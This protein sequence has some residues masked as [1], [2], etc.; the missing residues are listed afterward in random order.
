[1][2]YLDNPATSRKKPL[3]VTASL[4]YNSIVNSSNAGRG[5]HRYS[6]RGA[7]L[8]A[9][10]AEDTARLF[11][12]EDSGQ[13]AFTSGASLALNMAILGVLKN[14]G[15]AIVTSMEHN[16][17]LRPV[18]MMGAYTVVWADENGYVNPN[19]IE[20]AIEPDTKLIVCT[21]ASNVS[22]SIQPIAK[23]GAIARKHGIIFL[24]DCA[25][26]AGSVTINVEEMNIDLLAFSGHKGLA[27]PLGTGGLYVRKNVELSP[28]I[29]GGTGSLSES[30]LQPDFMPDMLQTGTMNTPAIAALGRAVRVAQDYGIER[31]LHHERNLAEEFI[32][33]IIASQGV[34]VLGGCDM[35]RRNGTVAF[36]IDGIESGKAAEILDSKYHIAVRGG[37]HCAYL[38]HKTLGTEKTGAV[39][40]GFGRYNNRAQVKKLA[41]AVRE[42]S[43]GY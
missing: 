1:M 20:A 4:I 3:Q 41:K 39:R 12:I 21:H 24:V 13:I 42:I 27:G 43:K 15:S 2:I 40:V 8:I 34:R 9:A 37:W 32:E 22:G 31:I 25:Q 16:S 35:N 18:H 6:L 28:I 19:D 23:I 38:A 30:L 14:G 36:T 5:S 7:G 33:N 11:G 29:T 17:V 26:T 10:A